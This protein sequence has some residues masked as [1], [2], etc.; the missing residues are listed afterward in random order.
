MKNRRPAFLLAVLLPAFY[1]PLSRA[2]N[3]E[4]WKFL[5][6]LTFVALEIAAIIDIIRS[7]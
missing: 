5:L 1:F 7:R 4:P 3:V 6:F 2:V